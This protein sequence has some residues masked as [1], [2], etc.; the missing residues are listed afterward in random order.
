MYV[1]H[2]CSPGGK[3]ISY[4]NV[5]KLK[6][7]N[8]KWAGWASRCRPATFTSAN[9]TYHNATWR[10]KVNYALLYHNSLFR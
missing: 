5:Q 10:A 3:T 2:L 9:K 6:N 7:C 8:G 1:V 4:I